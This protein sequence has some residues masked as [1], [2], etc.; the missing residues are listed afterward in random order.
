LE[1]KDDNRILTLGLSLETRLNLGK[2]EK[3]EDI[4]LASKRG[5]PPSLR[6]GKKETT[7]AIAPLYMTKGKFSPHFGKKKKKK[8]VFALHR[9]T[10]GGRGKRDSLSCGEKEGIC[11]EGRRLT[12]LWEGERSL[13]K[14]E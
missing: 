14:G 1:K 6:I 2:E 13:F 12:H 8:G 11:F 5:E 3:A 10:K 4:D 9:S 7:E